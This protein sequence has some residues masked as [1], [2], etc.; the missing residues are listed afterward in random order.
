MDGGGDGVDES[1]VGVGGEVDDDL[2]AGRD[3]GGDF[4][5][6]HDFSVGAVSVGGSVFA[7]V[8]ETAVTF[9]AFRPRE[10]K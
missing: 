3:G 4:D 10:L 1:L 8:D 2:R 7:A 5:I 6:E 9:G